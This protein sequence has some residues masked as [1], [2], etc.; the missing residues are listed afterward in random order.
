MRSFILSIAATL[1]FTVFSFAVPMPAEAS[2]V[3]AIA[4]RHDDHSKRI[5][6]EVVVKSKGFSLEV[7]LNTAI[8]VITPITE[9]LGE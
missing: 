2:P 4:A 6:L 7:V 8:D 5:S 9:E 1:A 3:N